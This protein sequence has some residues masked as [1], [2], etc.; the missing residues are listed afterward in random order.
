M[1]YAALIAGATGLIGGQLLAQVGKFNDYG[2]VIAIARRPLAA[3][4]HVETRIVNF[5]ALAPADC[6]GADVIFC[7]LGTTIKKAGSQD[8]F[9]RV[10][11][12]YVK[13]L[14]KTSHA[15]GAKQFVLVSSIGADANSSNF[16]LRV[17]GE[18]EQAITAMPFRAIHIFR[19]SLLL[20]ARNESRAGEGIGQALMP[21]LNPILVGGLRKYRAIPAADVARAMAV[22]PLQT[23]A[24][25]HTYEYDQIMALARG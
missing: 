10:D 5:D 8:A 11:L 21:V 14:A 19:P 18:V 9:Q 16:Y 17:K 2:H 6:A 3:S 7:A 20:G 23:P 22:A 25:T 15:A 4:A 12:G 13:R 1:A 24:G